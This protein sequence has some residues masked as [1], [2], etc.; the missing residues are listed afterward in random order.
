L[1]G[2]PLP[3]DLVVHAPA[4]ARVV[5]TLGAQPSA[6]HR[7]NALWRNGKAK[8]TLDRGSSRR[9]RV[10]DPRKWSCMR[11][12]MRQDLQDQKWRALWRA[13]PRRARAPRQAQ[14]GGAAP[15]HPGRCE[16]SDAGQVRSE[17]DLAVVL[18]RGLGIKPLA[19]LALSPVPG[20]VPGV[21]LRHLAD[22]SL[23]LVEVGDD[24]LVGEERSGTSEW[25]DGRPGPD[26]GDGA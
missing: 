19:G 21:R 25:D 14:I 10:T 4:R 3:W 26:D 18:R 13:R 15:L 16:A 1:H 2:V 22:T 20:V 12:D 23:R 7:A 11:D 6:P 8:G 24:P 5:T 17:D 9:D